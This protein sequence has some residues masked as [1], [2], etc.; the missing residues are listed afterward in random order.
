MLPSVCRC[1]PRTKPTIAFAF[2]ST[3][4]SWLAENDPGPRF[5][6]LVNAH[7]T[8]ASKPA[9]SSLPLL[10]LP[11]LA[12]TAQ[13]RS[14]SAFSSSS[15]NPFPTPAVASMHLTIT[16]MYHGSYNLL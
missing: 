8:G 1:T 9:P 12:S 14:A 2:P 13:R 15:G 4:L 11:L 10:K 6:T 3:W 7:N 16:V 5:S